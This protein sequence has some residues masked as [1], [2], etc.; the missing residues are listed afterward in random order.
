MRSLRG[1]LLL[2]FGA[3]G[4]TVLLGLGAA[5]FVVLRDLERDAADGALTDTAVQLVSRTR[6]QLT[7]GTAPRTVIASLEGDVSSLGFSLLLVDGR[8]TVLAAGGSAPAPATVDLSRPGPRGTLA[9]GSYTVARQAQAFV[10]VT[11]SGPASARGSRVLVLSR[12]DRSAAAALG[13]L[14][15]AMVVAILVVL[16][17]GG[18]LAIGLSRSV[19]RPLERLAGA[20]ASLTQGARPPVLPEDGPSEVARASA[21]FNALSA[22]LSRSRQEQ[23]DLLAN[24]GHDLRTPLTVIGGYAQALRDGTAQGPA[25]GRAATAIG[26]EASRLEGLVDQLGALGLLQAGPTLRVEQLDA[27]DLV[28]AA[29]SRFAPAA[30]AAGQTIE[31]PAAGPTPLPFAADR[32]AVERVLGNLVRNAL[33]AA[34]APGGHARLEATALPAGAGLAGPSVLLAVRDDGPGIPAA[35]LGRIFERFYRADPSRQGPG[36]GLGL[37]IVAELAQAHGGRAFAEDPVGGGARVGVLL[38]ATPNL[39]GRGAATTERG[40]PPVRPS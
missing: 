13:D 2:A 23:R 9:H 21:G 34:P 10:A 29:A 15:R 24:L 4:L 31:A 16:V 30:E 33:A 12:P 27:G 32:S 26:Q 19:A 14:A 40:S 1:R 38:P 6:S 8:G 20:A 37:A 36:A 35:S 5:L 7:A 3:L 17:V 18:L 25:A 28:R 22:E 11:I 39:E